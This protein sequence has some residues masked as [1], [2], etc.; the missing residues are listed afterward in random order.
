MEKVIRIALA[1]F[2]GTVVT[3]LTAWYTEPSWH[4]GLI[5]GAVSGMATYH[6]PWLLRWVRRILAHFHEYW[7]KII[8]GLSFMACMLIG[9]ISLASLVSYTALLN[10]TTTFFPTHLTL[11]TESPR[12]GFVC[13][14]GFLYFI[15]LMFAYAG[16]NILKHRAQNTLDLHEGREMSL[17]ADTIFRVPFMYPAFV[18]LC[19]LALRDAAENLMPFLREVIRIL[20]INTAIWCAVN[21]MGMGG[22]AFTISRMQHLEGGSVIAL[23][24]IFGCI[25]AIIGVAGSISRLKERETAE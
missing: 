16:L 2:L 12:I 20:Q 22:I 8:K 21:A 14:Y 4:L 25:G 10:A 23:A 17:V 13:M 15:F 6:F 1:C 18:V 19:I 11:F 3:A 7:E 5:A 9:P 24:M